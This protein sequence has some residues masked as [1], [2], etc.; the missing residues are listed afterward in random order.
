MRH[1]DLLR[2]AKHDDNVTLGSDGGGGG[3]GGATRAAAAGG[4]VGA[5]YTLAWDVPSLMA[6]GAG[7]SDG[8]AW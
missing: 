6:R 2:F 3:G 1:Y 5:K 4:L 7:E 8:G